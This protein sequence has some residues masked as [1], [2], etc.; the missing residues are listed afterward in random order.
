MQHES[1]YNLTFRIYFSGLLEIVP[2]V[3]RRAVRVHCAVGNMFQPTGEETRGETSPHF[4]CGR[5][6]VASVRT[7]YTCVH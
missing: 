2:L 1:E 5:A 7:G 3:Q 6:R 4:V